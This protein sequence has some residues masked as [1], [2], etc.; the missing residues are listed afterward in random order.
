MQY[1]LD[2]IFGEVD[3]EM[4]KRTSAEL[5]SGSSISINSDFATKTKSAPSDAIYSA[6]FSFITTNNMRGLLNAL[7]GQKVTAIRDPRGYSLLTACA[8]NDNLSAM[9]VVCD[10]ARLSNSEAALTAWANHRT[11]KGYT[12]LHFAAYHGNVQM[13]SFLVDGLAAD[14]EVKN[15]LG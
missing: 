13:M 15:E 14:I 8:L 7:V 4:L 9:K 6:I 3:S 2:S 10:C 12:A 1:M 11:K 5:T